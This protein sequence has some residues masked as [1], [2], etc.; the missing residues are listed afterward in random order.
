MAIF[1]GGFPATYQPV[2][3]QPVQYQP[4]QYQQQQ[5]QQGQQQIQPVSS[6][7]IWVQGEEA[8][9]A[10]L[11]APNCTVP[12]YDTERRT[13]YWKSVDSSGRPSM[14]YLDY[15]IR[16]N[17]TKTP[18]NAVVSQSTTPMVEYAGKAEQDALRAE[19][20]SYK[21]EIESLRAD[22]EAFRGDLYGIAGKK[23]ATRKKEATTDE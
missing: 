2:Q 4:I 17:A 1:N 12:L 7:V 11:V 19:I 22:L 9:K 3:Y 13:I 14:Q 15:T 10:Y 20:A 23:P 21:G 6:N 16:E 8:A 18:V 5:M